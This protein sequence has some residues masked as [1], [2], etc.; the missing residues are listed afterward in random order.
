MYAICSSD[1]MPVENVVLFNRE[2]NVIVSKAVVCSADVH[3][4]ELLSIE[5]Q[6]GNLTGAPVNGI[7]T[8]AC[9][10][11]SASE[12]ASLISFVVVICCRICYQNLRQNMVFD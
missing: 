8:D 10:A 2:G 5:T 6:L 9:G 1:A 11:I 7:Y 12:R 3:H 4:N